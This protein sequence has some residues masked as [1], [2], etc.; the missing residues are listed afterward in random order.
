MK[1]KHLLPEARVM[2]KNPKLYQN[3][4]ILAE[5]YEKWMEVRA[6]GAVDLMLEQ[7]KMLAA[8]K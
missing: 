5:K 7:V 8:K 2:W 3:L 4:A 1:V 6:P